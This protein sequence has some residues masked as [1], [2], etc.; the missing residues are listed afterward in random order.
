MIYRDNSHSAIYV[1]STFT[2]LNM[3]ENLENSAMTTGLEKVSFH[4]NSKEKKCQGM[5]KLPYFT[6]KQS[7]AQNSPTQASTVHEPRTP[8]VQAGFRKGRGTRYQIVNIHWITE[9]QENSRKISTLASLTTLK[10][11]GSQQTVENS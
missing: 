11:C 10:Q 8:D 9:K 6:R 5:F 3:L 1:H 7:N 4:S 2:A